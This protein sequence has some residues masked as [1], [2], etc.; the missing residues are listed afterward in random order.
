ME[1]VCTERLGSVLRI[2]LAQPQ[3]MNCM[4]AGLC[5]ALADAV[6]A[7]ERDDAVRAVILTGTGRAF[8]AGGDLNA[9]AGFADP[10]AAAAYVHEAGRAAEAI[11]CGKKPYVAAVNG[12]A[13]GAG[14]NLALACDFILAA[15]T[16]KFT[17]AFSSVGLISDCG[18]NYLLPRAVGMQKA[19]ELMMLP[20]MLSAK[21]AYDLGFVTRVVPNEELESAALDFA[22]ALAQRP[23]RAHAACKRLVNREAARDFRDM[24]AL[25]EEIQ[26]RLAVGHDAKEGIAAFFEK[27]SAQ[28]TG[29]S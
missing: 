20:V 19:K 17:Q 12:A 4:T 28:F 18:G 21:E 11:F 25:E 1:S 5:A 13:A 7:A 15:E 22:A 3:N 26:G 10:A 8:C 9:I 16:A 6:A 27:R 14:F 2:T 23:A 24:C 29:E